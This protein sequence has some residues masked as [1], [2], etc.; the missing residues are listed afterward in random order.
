MNVYLKKTESLRGNPIIRQIVDRQHTADSYCR[1][2]RAV[3]QEISGRYYTWVRLPKPTRRG[4]WNEAVRVHRENR[5]LY[6]RV[7]GGRI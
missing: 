6:I 3:V 5:R 7:M 1:V 2:L 4:I